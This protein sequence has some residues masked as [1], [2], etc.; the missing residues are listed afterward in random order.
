M[1]SVVTTR[2]PG[3]VPRQ[4]V[5]VSDLH[6]GAGDRNDRFNRD[7]EFIAFC[8]HLA[9]TPPTL[10]EARRMVVVGDFL[11]L[12]GV[13]AAGE[14]RLTSSVK[15]ALARLDR[16]VDAHGAVFA[17]MADLVDVGWDI[18]VVIGNHDI[19]LIRPAVQHRLGDLLGRGRRQG[20]PVRFHPWIFHVPGVLYAEHG[21][22]YHDI[23]WFP[24]LVW[25][26]GEDGNDPISHPLAAHLGAR[27][28]VPAMAHVRRLANQL[29][30]VRDPR[31]RRYRSGGLTALSQ[32]VA[33]SR[34]VLR[35]IDLVPAASAGAMALRLVRQLCRRRQGGAIYLRRA[36][37]A[38]DGILQRAG[39]GCAFYAF[40]HSH[41]TEHRCLVDGEQGPEYLNVGTWSLDVRGSRRGPPGEE[42]GTFAVI[43]CPPGD[44]PTAALH[45]WSPQGDPVVTIR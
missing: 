6:M 17:A 42:R 25:A 12:L 23:N 41:A 22:Q 38:V 36:A 14:E 3:P 21:S 11:E 8:H 24:E 28:A 18:D 40:G 7:R 45:S 30:G 5:L 35:R 26:G 16:I 43:D 33:L 32:E 37:R 1:V 20:C 29:L 9:G 4:L 15:V 27:P 44:R 19:D 2:T 10:R 39:A 31:R 13:R 34:E